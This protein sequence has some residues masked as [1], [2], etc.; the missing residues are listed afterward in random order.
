MKVFLLCGGRGERLNGLDMP[1][2]MCIVRGKSI[3]YHVID[4]L[5]L[6]IKE[7]TIVYTNYLNKYEFKRTVIHSCAELGRKL[8]FIEITLVTR[9]PVETAY[10]GLQGCDDKEKVLFIDNDTINTFD[11]RDI[12]SDNLN[13]GT[14]ITADLTKPYSYVKVGTERRVTQIKEK[15]SISNTYNTGLY[16]FPSVSCY[17]T[18]AKNLFDTEPDKREYFMSDLYA[19]AL[20]GGMPVYSFPCLKSISLGTRVDITENISK[21]QKYTMR[22]CFDIDNTLITYSENPKSYEGIQPI[23]TMIQLVRKLH[24]EGNTIVLH[25]A[26]GMKSC[27]SN[28]GLMAKKVYMNVLECLEK[29]EVSYD[30]IYFG[31]PYADIYI[32]D[33]AWNQYTNPSF[34]EF[35]FDQKLETPVLYLPKNCSNNENTL[36]L[37]DGILVKEGP[38][39]SLEGEIYFYEQAP[40]MG[41]IGLFPEFHGSFDKGSNKCLKIQHLAGSS[42]SQYFRNGLLT[43]AIMKRIARCLERLHSVPF[44]D[45]VTKSDIYTNYI[46][47]L[48]ER[49]KKHPNYRLPLIEDVF[50]IIKSTIQSY[51]NADFSFVGCVHG[52]PWFDNM[53]FS[54]GEIKLLD[55]KGK[56]GDQFTLAGDRMTDWAKLYQSILGF[57]FYLNGEA[58]GELYENECRAM[59]KKVLPF[60]IDD[61]VFEAVTACCVLKTFSFFS[62]TEP[63]PAIYRSLGKMRLFSFIGG[64]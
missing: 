55:M 45:S 30:E 62:K 35:F 18:L 32:D 1:K 26:R 52:D 9:G 22:I 7:I 42:V 33:K 37:S 57:D 38:A 51:L 19:L 41:L 63:I 59:L 11:I 17:R 31:K 40:R 20:Q 29:L 13:L 12:Q 14:A 8:N 10:V 47:K 46:V 64:S 43:E 25:T 61:P 39:S 28:Q 24:S 36:Y 44:S 6:D 21:V 15:V 4:G 27:K 5:P 48:E 60:P 53:M 2:P 50:I 56:L 54:D 49:I 3:I 58:Y 16:F 34:S 23:N